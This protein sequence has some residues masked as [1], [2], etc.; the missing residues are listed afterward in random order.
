MEFI[1]SMDKQEKEG[2]QFQPF[3]MAG[4][5]EERLRSL[6]AGVEQDFVIC[7]HTHIQFERSLDSMHIVNAGSV[8]M[9][10]AEKPG[11][12]WLLLDPQGYE[13]RRTEYDREAA[14]QEIL[15]TA[16]PSA[17]QFAKENVLQVHTARDATAYFE[18]IAI[19]D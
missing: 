15:A 8:G 12:Y 13:W 1:H 7:G 5:T 6:F 19:E 18:S 11:A 2:S 10:Y 16:Y 9:P 3:S 14:S 17:E 4:C